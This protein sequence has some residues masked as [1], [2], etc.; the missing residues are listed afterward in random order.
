MD[1]I[2]VANNIEHTLV[3]VE[4]FALFI[5]VLFV[6]SISSARLYF[7]VMPRSPYMSKQ[8]SIGLIEVHFITSTLTFLY[9]MTHATAF[10]NIFILF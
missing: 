2:T 9:L 1:S 6:F 5:C 8:M 3:L 7:N 10:F 4:Q